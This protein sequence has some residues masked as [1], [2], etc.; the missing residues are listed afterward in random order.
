MYIIFVRIAQRDSVSEKNLIYI[1]HRQN[2]VVRDTLRAQPEGLK[3]IRKDV[4]PMKLRSEADVQEFLEAVKA[5]EGDV[6]LKSPEGDI[7]NL[8]SSL[9][10]YV[11]LGHLLEKEGDRLELFADRRED[12]AL[13]MR[14]VA[15]LS[16]GDTP[17]A[18]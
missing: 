15:D 12:R 11:A 9:S 17:A 3:I 10:R 6:Y 13:L 7:F 18:S 8:K 16:G 14:M 2:R 5:C 1:I 4:F